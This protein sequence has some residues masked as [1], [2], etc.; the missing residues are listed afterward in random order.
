MKIKFQPLFET[1]QNN[2]EPP[3]VS[4]KIVPQWYKEIPKFFSRRK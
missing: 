4:S 2:I 1:T 3:I